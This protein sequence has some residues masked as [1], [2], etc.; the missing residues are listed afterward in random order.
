M[1][2]IYP[3]L[4]RLEFGSAICHNLRCAE[5]AVGTLLAVAP[6]SL[7]MENQEVICTRLFSL[8]P[9][10][11]LWGRTERRPLFHLIHRFFFRP[12]LC[13]TNRQPHIFFWYWQTDILF[14]QTD[15]PI[16]DPLIFI[17]STPPRLPK[18]RD[19]ISLWRWSN[20]RTVAPRYYLPRRWEIS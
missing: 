15:R 5:I 18:F 8:K 17:F 7:K 4:W 1:T 12:S 16:S 14:R 6:R 10:A 19:L 9:T 20:F 3:L 11:G 2:P 13:L